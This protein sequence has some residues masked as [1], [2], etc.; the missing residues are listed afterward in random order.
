MFF[1]ILTCFSQPTEFEDIN[2]LKKKADNPN[3]IYGTIIT[4]GKIR[5]GT[6]P[7]SDV[8]YNFERSDSIELLDHYQGY[9]G[10]NYNNIFGYTSEMYIINNKEIIAF[11]DSIFSERIFEKRIYEK[12]DSLT[13]KTNIYKK[14]I[15]DSIRNLEIQ[16]RDC[17]NELI[18]KKLEHYDRLS[19]ED[20]WEVLTFIGGCLLGQEYCKNDSSCFEECVL[21]ESKYWQF[22]FNEPKE[23]LVPFLIEKICDTTSTNIH[24]C[25]MFSTKQGELAVYCLQFIYRTNWFELSKEYHKYEN[26]EVLGFETTHQW[27]LWTIIQD[28]NKSEKMKSL[29]LKLYK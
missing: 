5:L 16:I 13:Y 3:K 27:I 14:L 18:Q 17:K 25:P 19:V 24:T 22:F 21:I 29:W 6:N 28:K 10:V 12:I 11:K 20:Q 1:G 15:E 7:L 26:I 8:I 2:C 23:K 4:G 9:W